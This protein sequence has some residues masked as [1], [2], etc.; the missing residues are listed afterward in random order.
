MILSVTPNPA[1]DRTLLVRGHVHGGTLRTQETLVAAGGKGINVA[2]TVK[3]LGAEATCA[4]FLAGHSGRFIAEK[5]ADEGLASH[6][7]NIK[8]RESRSC[9]I[10]IDPETNQ[11]AVI[12]ENG[13]RLDMFDWEHLHDDILEAAQSAS[14]VCFCG[15]VPPSPNLS[16]YETLLRQ[17]HTSGKPVWVDSSGDALTCAASVQ[18]IALKVNAE[19]AAALLNQPITNA[20]SAASAAQELHQKSSAPVVITLG[21]QGAV[22]ADSTGVWHAEPPTVTVKN[23]VGSGDAFLGGLLVALEKGLPV[24]DALKQATATGTVNALSVAMASFE[25]D[26]L[27]KIA[28]ETQIRQI[29]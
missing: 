1:I 10:L 25:L 5:V 9:I 14:I 29:G 17:L 7:T 16:V 20:E 24:A 6:W 15:S 22:Y 18:G 21:I 13:P 11:T 8:N 26:E 4:G 27:Q 19:E 28:D 12:N 2:R 23:A 3:R